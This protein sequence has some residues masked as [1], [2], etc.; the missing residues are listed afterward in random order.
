MN[1]HA[2]QAPSEHV[3]SAAHVPSQQGSPSQPHAA[4]H[5]G[6]TPSHISGMSDPQVGI[7]QT[8]VASRNSATHSPS[9]HIGAASHAMR[10]LASHTRPHIPQFMSSL[11]VSTHAA[12]QRTFGATHS[13]STAT[14]ATGASTLASV[15][16]SNAES[17]PASPM[18]SQPSSVQVSPGKH[19][20]PRSYWHISSIHCAA[21]HGVT[22][23]QSR[24]VTQP[25]RTIQT[26]SGPQI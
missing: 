8:V 11:D 18:T 20:E 14:S 23:G 21:A 7:R 4:G 5:S 26:A 25:G 24:I 22:T 3:R 10:P 9:T 16:E 12:P 1:V 2:E 13:A 19:S 15:L 17:T 6:A